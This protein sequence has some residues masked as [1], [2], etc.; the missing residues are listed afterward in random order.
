MSAYVPVDRGNPER[1]AASV[2]VAVEHMRQGVSYLVYP[3]G[4]RSRSGRLL[5]FR[6]GAFALA[7][8]AGAPVV[9]VACIGAHRVL[10][11][12]AFRIRPGEI[13]VKFCPAIDAREY[14]LDQR[15]ELAQRVHAAIAAA[16]PPDQQPEQRPDQQAGATAKLV[17]NERA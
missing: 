15:G 7:I 14:S 12:N 6:K 1:A 13:T 4:T 17:P 10:P 9:P 5:P 11:K 16:L 8:K 3:E 2:D